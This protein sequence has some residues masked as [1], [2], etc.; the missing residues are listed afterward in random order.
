M[1]VPQHGAVTLS[2]PSRERV[3]EDAKDLLRYAGVSRIMRPMEGASMVRIWGVELPRPR[4]A[5]SSVAKE[6]RQSAKRTRS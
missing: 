4:D 3:I 1:E 6:L 5:N 2:G